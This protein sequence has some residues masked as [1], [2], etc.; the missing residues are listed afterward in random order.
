MGHRQS[1]DHVT[2]CKRYD[3]S[4]HSKFVFD[5]YPYL[6]LPSFTECYR[7]LPSF[8]YIWIALLWRHREG[9]QRSAGH[10]GVVGRQRMEQK[11]CNKIELERNEIEK[12]KETRGPRPSTFDRLGTKRRDRHAH[13]AD[14]DRNLLFFGLVSQSFAPTRLDSKRHL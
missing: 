13:A 8:F 1:T 9:I 5:S 14:L 12:A 7:V 3:H 4:F 10:P 6:V 11:K 2:A